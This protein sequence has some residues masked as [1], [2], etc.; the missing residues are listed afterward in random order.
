[1]LGFLG[2]IAASAT[3]TAAELASVASKDEATIIAL[4]GDVAEGDAD[5]VEALI[6]SANQNGRLVAALRLDSPGG[7]L[8]EAVK[9]ADLI[10]RAK[11]PTMV[12]AGSRCASACFIVFA[13][14]IEKFAN[15]EAA[16]GVHGVSDKAGHETAQTEAATLA[17]ARLA[18]AYGV[19]PRIIGQMVVTP[20]QDMAWLKPDD[21]RSMGAIMTGQAGRP[22][23]PPAADD[24]RL[25]A[26]DLQFP[27][28][29]AEPPRPA[30]TDRRYVEATAAAS[31]GDYASA[32]RLWRRFADQGDGISQY[33]L[34][35]MYEAGQGVTRDFAEAAEWYRRAAEHGIPHA[36]LSLGV[37]YA[38]GRG[39]PQDFLQAH[40]WLNLAVAAYTADE[41][42]NRAVK[43]RDL[44]ATKMTPQDIAQAQ[45]L[46]RQWEQQRRR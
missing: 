3:G 36:R 17:M 33:N 19:P 7:S 29:I 9:L 2:A 39:V 21:L 8:N 20:A 31:R 40:K 18:S 15:Y 28:G 5:A 43:A 13:A 42:R 1:M 14:G 4:N 37:A 34:G 22:A 11:L 45:R 35:Q 16:I 25:A 24:R 26:L 46:A 6:R 30:P 32:I 23:A 12:A 44:V 41:D 38:L 10:R 27:G